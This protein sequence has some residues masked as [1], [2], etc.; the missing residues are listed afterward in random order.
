MLCRAEITLPDWPEGQMRDVDPTDERVQGFLRNAWITPLVRQRVQA[1]QSP[2]Q[3]S[4]A[5][6]RAKAG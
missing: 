2:E 1:P 6:K 3:P 5:A 4:P